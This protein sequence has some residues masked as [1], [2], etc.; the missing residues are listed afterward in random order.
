MYLRSV[1]ISPSE[2]RGG[3]CKSVSTA[4]LNVTGRCVMQLLNESVDE[5]DQSADDLKVSVSRLQRCVRYLGRAGMDFG[6]RPA[7]QVPDNWS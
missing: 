6:P 1:R 2:T 5:P 7:C 3:R 4:V